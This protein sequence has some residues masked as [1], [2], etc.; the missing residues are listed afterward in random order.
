MTNNTRSVSYPHLQ[1]TDNPFIPVP[2]IQGYDEDF[3]RLFTSR[4]K[5]V[6]KICRLASAPRGI[7]VI[8]PFGGGKTIVLLEAMSR[9]REAGVIPI[10]ASFDPEKGFRQVL[11]EAVRSMYGRLH[12]HN[13]DRHQT[14]RQIVQ[15]LRDNGREVVLA[16]DDLDRAND[17][18]EVKQVTDDVRD[19]LSDGASVVITGQEF[20]VTF[21]LHTSAGGVFQRV[22]I[23]A[24]T[25]GEFQQL[26]EKYLRSVHAV[27]SLSSIHPFDAEGVKFMCQEMAQANMTPRLFNFAVC[28]LIEICEE[29]G[30]SFIPCETVEGKWPKLAQHVVNSLAPQQL[31][32][33]EIILNAKVVS[34]DTPKAIAELGGHRYAEFPEVRTEVLRPLVEK[35]I[36]YVTK[37]QGK[38]QYHLTPQA[39][40]AVLEIQETSASMDFDLII[41]LIA[42][43]KL[44]DALSAIRGNGQSLP[45]N[46]AGRIV[47]QLGR[48]ARSKQALLDGQINRE[49]FDAERTRVAEMLLGLIGE[50]QVS[51]ERATK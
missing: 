31:K 16:V 34:E 46:I 25:A 9:M 18:A 42:S 39:T 19:L 38:D 17:I 29:S 37:E 27:T 24:F 3:R 21:D 45:K 51:S 23:P 5:E 2:P 14:L 44:E 30:L 41:E 1:L 26:L 35:N 28:Q 15:T 7:F 12:G 8:A 10:Y 49:I 13:I 47:M 20:G 50:L 48:L 33:L 6:S 40:A 43:D 36:V 11:L 32:H 22:T 4:E